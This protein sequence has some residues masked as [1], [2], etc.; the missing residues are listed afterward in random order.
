MSYDVMF[1]D[2][3]SLH[4]N[5]F[6]SSSRSGVCV[7]GRLCCT[8]LCCAVLF[9]RVEAPVCGCCMSVPIVKPTRV[10][11]GRLDGLDAVYQLLTDRSFS[12]F[13][14]P[15][16]ELRIYHKY[17]KSTPPPWPRRITEPPPA[18]SSTSTLFLLQ[19]NAAWGW[20]LMSG[21]R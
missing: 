7:S 18:A 12:T 5:D 10:E 20:M 16:C 17:V 2:R 6:S 15:T 21:T 9:P 8:V 13:R 4:G 19:S 14:S 3:T 11:L 1:V